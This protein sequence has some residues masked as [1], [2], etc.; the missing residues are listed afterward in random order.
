MMDRAVSSSADTSF[1]KWD[2]V[3]LIYQ[4]GRNINPTAKTGT[5]KKLPSMAAPAAPAA[6]KSRDTVHSSGNVFSRSVA[7]KMLCTSS[8]SLRKKDFFF[9]CV[10][11]KISS[12]M[13][14]GPSRSFVKMF[15]VKSVRLMPNSRKHPAIIPRQAT[16]CIAIMS[17][18]LPL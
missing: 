12:R 3:S 9:L 4:K 15:P 5:R 14:F 18:H 16:T 7:F 1:L 11:S 2:A 13:P 17:F 10:C 6:N 8:I